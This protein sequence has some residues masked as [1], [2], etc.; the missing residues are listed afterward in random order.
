MPLEPFILG[1]LRILRGHL[2]LELDGGGYRLGDTLK[3]GQYGIPRLMDLL[4]TMDCNHIA[5]LPH[6]RAV[7]RASSPADEAQTEDYWRAHRAGRWLENGSGQ[8]ERR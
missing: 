4:A 1:Q 8:V 2:T 5:A 3:L 6:L 7:A